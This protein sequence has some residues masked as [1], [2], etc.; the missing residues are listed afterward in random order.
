MRVSGCYLLLNENPDLLVQIAS[1]DGLQ[2][3]NR[4]M[5]RAA[6]VEEELNQLEESMQNCGMV[7]PARDTM[8]MALGKRKCCDFIF[9]TSQA[10]EFRSQLTSRLDDQTN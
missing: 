9:T 4:L 7:L 1:L 5:H 8:M 10:S 6:T 2:Q 3:W